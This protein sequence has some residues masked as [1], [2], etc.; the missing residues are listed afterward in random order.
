[1][2]DEKLNALADQIANGVIEREEAE[3]RDGTVTLFMSVAATYTHQG[4]DIG[5]KPGSPED[6]ALTEAVN[7]RLREYNERKSRNM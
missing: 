3:Q 4:I 2:N 7:A 1:M 6:E 5:V